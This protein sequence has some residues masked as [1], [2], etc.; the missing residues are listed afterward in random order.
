MRV[1]C[2]TRFI[3]SLKNN[4]GLINID[5]SSDFSSAVVSM[6]NA[7]ALIGCPIVVPIISAVNPLLQRVIER[8]FALFS[9]DTTATVECAR[10]GIAYEMA[11]K[12]IN[13]HVA[14]GDLLRDDGFFDALNGSLYTKADEIIEACLKNVVNDAETQKSEV[15][16]KFLGSVPFLEGYSVSQLI[17]LNSI[18]R[19]LTI[20]DIENLRLFIDKEPHDFSDLETQVKIGGSAVDAHKFASLLHLKNVGLIARSASFKLG[21]DLENEKITVIGKELLEIICS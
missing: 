10:L 15:Y 8:G 16:G 21:M 20:E 7:A 6:M 9:R 5:N 4:Q 12:T 17:S 3:K 19:Q 14:K 2:F 13:N 11:V 1:N 18:L